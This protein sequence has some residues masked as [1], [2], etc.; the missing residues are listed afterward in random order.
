LQ[1]FGAAP[2]DIEMDK[3]RLEAAIEEMAPALYRY[4]CASFA[5]HVADDL[6]QDTLIRLIGKINDHSF[7]ARLGN[8]RM[9]A[10]GIA[11][12]V[13]MECLRSPQR[14]HLELAPTLADDAQ[15]PAETYEQ[16]RR[17]QMLRKAI[18]ALSEDQQQVLGLYLD[19]E[20]TYNEIGLILQMAT[21]TVKSHVS[22]AKEALKL[23]LK[24]EDES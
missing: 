18:R 2:Q 12:F 19:Q 14:N 20:L 10:F 6:V 8:L 24:S 5:Q 11:H 17:L 13:R 22:R 1:P 4:F 3:T 15:T 7:D 23:A 21:G 16:N 9:Y